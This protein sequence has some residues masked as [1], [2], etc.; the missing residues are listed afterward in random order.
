MCNKNNKIFNNI[1]IY[2]NNI[3][4]LFD[5]KYFLSIIQIAMERSQVV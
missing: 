4:N 5:S 1:K 3:Y 2:L